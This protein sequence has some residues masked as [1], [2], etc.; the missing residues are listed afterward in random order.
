MEMALLSAGH[1]SLD[2]SQ[3]CL[4]SLFHRM[5]DIEHGYSPGVVTGPGAREMEKPTTV[6]KQ[7][8][9]SFDIQ[10]QWTGG[11]SGSSSYAGVARGKD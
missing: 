3:H 1:G 8:W 6:R 4:Y 2:E 9:V 7:L 11:G 10:F 5:I